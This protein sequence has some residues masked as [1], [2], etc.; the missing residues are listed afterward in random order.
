MAVGGR[1]REVGVGGGGRDCVCVYG[2]GGGVVGG[3]YS[4]SF[5]SELMPDGCLDVTGRTVPSDPAT[6]GQCHSSRVSL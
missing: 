1:G 6:C 4:Y 2:G 3:D 5:Q